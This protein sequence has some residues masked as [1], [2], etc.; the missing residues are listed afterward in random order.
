[1]P[2]IPAPNQFDNNQTSNPALVNENFNNIINLLNGNVD[3]ANIASLAMSKVI[4]FLAHDHTNGKGGAI[5]SGAL[6]MGSGSGVDADKVDG[7]DS[8]KTA[9]ADTVAVRDSAGKL[10]ASDYVAGSNQVWHAGNMKFGDNYIEFPNS[11]IVQWG[12]CG[13][14]QT[15][16]T[17]PYTNNPPTVLVSQ[18]VTSDYKPASHLV[19][20]SKDKFNLFAYQVLGASTQAS[21]ATS[22]FWVAIGR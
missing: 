2:L 12:T 5:P 14:G 16:F 18:M 3:S 10:V 17:K 9:A 7:F 13:T 11:I 22:W 21:Y 1:M 15:I 6:V 4:G 20:S 8:A 19:E